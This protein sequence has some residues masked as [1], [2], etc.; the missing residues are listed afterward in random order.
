M[1]YCF[2]YLPCRERSWTIHLHGSLEEECPD[3]PIGAE[4]RELVV[5][6]G[7]PLHVVARRA[8]PLEQEDHR[9]RE[10]D[11]HEGRDHPR[12]DAKRFC[13]GKVRVKI[14]HSCQP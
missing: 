11:S 14:K 9:G 6:G 12:G 1:F 5:G 13:N 10:L 4:Q 7:G 3:Q 2:I 8:Q